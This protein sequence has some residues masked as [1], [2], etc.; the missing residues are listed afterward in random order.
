[1][2]AA[3]SLP[4]STFKDATAVTISIGGSDRIARRDQDV[5]AR[6]VNVSNNGC[7]QSIPPASTSSSSPFNS[8]ISLIMFVPLRW[9]G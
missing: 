9:R 3:N 2:D 1:V 7:L 6:A 5:A 4:A 8:R